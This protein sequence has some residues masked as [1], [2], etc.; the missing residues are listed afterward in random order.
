M[1]IFLKQK[2]LV[3]NHQRTKHISLLMPL[4]FWKVN[5][6]CFVR[7]IC[8]LNGIEF[9]QLQF[10]LVHIRRQD[11]SPC[12]T[13]ALQTPTFP[14]EI[15][16]VFSFSLLLSSSNFSFFWPRTPQRSNIPLQLFDVKELTAI[17][18]DLIRCNRVFFS[19]IRNINRL[20]KQINSVSPSVLSLR[21]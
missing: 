7:S 13:T 11:S 17:Q 20:N 12:S 18:T 1:A 3:W 14:F 8:V 2:V 5:Q 19:H 4:P 16:N 15:S 9:P 6:N 21:F 10:S